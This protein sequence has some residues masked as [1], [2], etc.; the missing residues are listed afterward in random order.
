M[1]RKIQLPPNE[2]FRTTEFHRFNKFIWTGRGKIEELTSEAPVH[3]QYGNTLVLFFADK[4]L[5]IDLK[6]ETKKYEPG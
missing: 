2:F 5:A 4:I 3:F 1:E 6:T